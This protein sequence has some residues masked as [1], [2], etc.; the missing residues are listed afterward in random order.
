MPDPKPVGKWRLDSIHLGAEG[1][2]KVN[3]RRNALLNKAG[4]EGRTIHSKIIAVDA[5]SSHELWYYEL[6]REED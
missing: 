5:N 6:P 4:R 2:S 3:T 1:K